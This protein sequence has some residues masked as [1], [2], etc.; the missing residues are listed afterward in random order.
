MAL[1]LNSSRISD[2]ASPVSYSLSP[3]SKPR[4]NVKDILFER[5]STDFMKE[6]NR[7]G[8]RG[9]S[10][11]PSGSSISRCQKST[12]YWISSLAP[13]SPAKW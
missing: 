11:T 3:L 13:P 1:C 5:Q 12:Q 9:E 2:Q 8:H 6:S 7:L 10:S 4:K